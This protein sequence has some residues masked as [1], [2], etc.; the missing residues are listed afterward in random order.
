MPNKNK[1]ALWSETNLVAAL[2]AIASGS[3]ISQAAIRYEI[4]RT[5][6]GLHYRNQNSNKRLGRKSILSPDQ[7]K[8]LVSRIHKLAEIGMPITSKMVRKSVFSYATAMN[9]ENP[10]STTSKLAGRK[11]LKLFFARHPDVSK[12]KAQQM[13]PARAQKMNPGI[14]NDYFAKLKAILTELELFDKPGNVYNMDEKGCRLTIHKQ[15]T[16]LAKKGAKRVHLTAPEHGENVS[17][18]GCGNALGQAIPPFILFKGKRLK[19]EWTDHLPPGSTAMMTQKGSMTN[20]AFIS[21]LAHFEKFKNAGPTLL[22]FDGAKSHLDISIVEAAENYGVTLFCL[23]SN[24]THELQPMDKAVFKSYE[25]FWDQEVLNFLVTQPGKTLTKMRFGEIFSKVWLKAMTPANIIS[26]FRA[27]GIFPFQPDIIPESAFA[28]SLITYVEEKIQQPENV[29]DKRFTCD[30]ENIIKQIPSTSGISSTTTA[31]KENKNPIKRPRSYSD[32]STSESDFSVHDHSSDDINSDD[33]DLIKKISLI[34]SKTTRA[35]GKENMAPLT[36]EQDPDTSFKSV[37]LLITPEIQIS[38]TKRKPALNS[39]AQT[40]TKDLFFAASEKTPKGKQP[41]K[42][43][44]NAQKIKGKNKDKHENNRNQQ[45]KQDR[46]INKPTQTLDKKNK[47]K[48]KSSESWFCFIC[49]EDRQ[50]DMRLCLA[51][52]RYVHEECV[53]LTEDDKDA[54][55]CP[56]CS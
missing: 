45:E 40:V 2:E 13:N 5:T 17:I 4:P 16:V 37:G 33:E 43:Q 20:E 23:P 26:G 44:E 56:N 55:K 7:E 48:N 11:W 49:N 47:K 34:S 22:I 32:S 35:T 38:T 28:P 15:Q 31:T 53:G 52:E 9:I 14:V 10:F 3:S 18:V 27:T 36:P 30:D 39:K 8:D 29:D 24:T 54:F 12:R 25:S 51:C 6:L 1:R 21:W 46:I 42:Q 19:P 50:T 41:L